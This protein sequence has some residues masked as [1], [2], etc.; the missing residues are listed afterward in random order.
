M[1]MALI[2]TQIKVVQYCAVFNRKDLTDSN[3]Y[4]AWQNHKAGLGQHFVVLESC[5][6][7]TEPLQR[8]KAKSQGPK[9]TAKMEKSKEKKGIK[10]RKGRK[11]KEEH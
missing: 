9:K 4:D 3:P 2:K 10:V 1:I 8:P 5:V 7:H 11:G 6:R